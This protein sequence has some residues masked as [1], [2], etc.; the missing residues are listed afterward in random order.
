MRAFQLPI[1]F[2]STSEKKSGGVGDCKSCLLAKLPPLRLEPGG[3]ALKPHQDKGVLPSPQ[4]YPG[5]VST[6]GLSGTMARS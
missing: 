6:P 4:L 1:G 5:A 2:N 3:Q